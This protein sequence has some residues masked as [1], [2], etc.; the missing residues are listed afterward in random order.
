MSNAPVTVIPVL[1]T[2]AVSTEL[3]EP[4]ELDP[5]GA[6]VE[7]GAL[8]EG[9]EVGECDPEEQALREMT[10]VTTKA[11]PVDPPRSTVRTALP[12]GVPFVVA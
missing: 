10:A 5:P 2:T 6:V 8:V 12:I 9:L 1:A 4:P 3:E 7:V 11:I